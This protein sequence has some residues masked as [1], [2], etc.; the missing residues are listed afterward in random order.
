[1]KINLQNTIQTEEKTTTTMAVSGGV[2][3]E[4]RVG[5]FYVEAP[6]SR[7]LSVV[8]SASGAM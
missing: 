5:S 2:L 1:M 3:W 4:V 6:P 7:N 8:V